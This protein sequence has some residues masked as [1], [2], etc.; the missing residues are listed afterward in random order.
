MKRLLKYWMLSLA[1]VSALGACSDD[2]ASRK[3]AGEAV[4][5]IVDAPSKAEFEP[6]ETRTWRVSSENVETIGVSQPR[7]WTAACDGEELTV[8]APA[9]EAGNPEKEGDVVIV[10]SGRNGAEKRATLAVALTLEVPGPQP[11]LTFELVCSGVTAVSAELQVTPSDKQAGYYY[12]VCTAT[13]YEEH[14]GDVGAMVEGIIAD[15]ASR[16]PQIPLSDILAGMLDRGDSSDTVSGLPCDTDMCFFAVGIDERG[17]SY[18]TAAVKTFRTLAP[19]NPEDCTFGFEFEQLLATSV[20]IETIPSDPTISYWTSIEEV[21]S[22]K[23]DAA[24]PVLVKETLVRYA[25]ENGMSVEDV[26][27]GVTFEGIRTDAWSDGIEPNTAY[28]AYA[29]AMDEEGNAAGPLFKKQFT[30]LAYDISEAAVSLVYRYFDGE[31]LYDADSDKY[32][33]ARGKVL[34]Q[35]KASPNDYA[36]TWVVG[37]GAGDMTDRTLYPDETTKNALLQAGQ[38]NR[39]LQQFWVDGW[40]VCTLMACAFDGFGVDGELSRELLEL[41]PEGAAPLEE[42][43]PIGSAAYVGLPVAPAASG[44]SGGMRMRCPVLP[45]AGGFGRAA[46]FRF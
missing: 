4:L 36:A 17:E 31:M 18:G 1:C 2:D 9:P 30:T 35:V 24:V 23:G 16:N 33:D 32:P 34:V 40:K 20:T 5:S 12:D 3:P 42:L 6:G 38:L 10:Y 29:Y 26:V 46:K 13:T 8:T 14:G 39:N 19:G 15:F 25:E 7:G 37:L 22:W 43:A 21:G 41:T 44:R 45:E 28:Y 27:K 11:E